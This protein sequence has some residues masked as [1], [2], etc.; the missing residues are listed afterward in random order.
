MTLL[1]AESLGA[2]FMDRS[3]KKYLLLD[4]ILWSIQM[5]ELRIGH[6][7]MVSGQW[8]LEGHKEQLHE[9]WNSSFTH[10]SQTKQT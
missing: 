3:S 5:E 4:Q 8:Q 6:W 7:S 10:P 2:K 9:D 1:Y